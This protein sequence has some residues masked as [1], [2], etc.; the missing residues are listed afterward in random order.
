M[1]HLLAK[2][3]AKSLLFD[4]VEIPLVRE[5]EDPETKEQ[6]ANRINDRA[7]EISSNMQALDLR[8]DFACNLTTHHEAIS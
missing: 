3:A 4:F 7:V 6:L 1:R 2:Q 8:A 5:K